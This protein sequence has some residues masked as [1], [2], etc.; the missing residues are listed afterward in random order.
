MLAMMEVMEDRS[1]RNARDSVTL[2]YGR[3]QSKAILWVMG[4]I[5]RLAVVVK[6]NRKQSL[7]FDL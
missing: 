6:S 1:G 5:G 7:M 2:H 4:G 3:A